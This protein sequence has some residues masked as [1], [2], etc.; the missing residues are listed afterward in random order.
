VDIQLRRLEHRLAEQRLSLHVTPAARAALAEEG[1]D[2]VYGARPLR[3]DD[4]ATRPGSPGEFKP[5]DTVVVDWVDD[6]GFT[7]A[8]AVEAEAVPV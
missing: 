6:A 5:G 8:P 4:S 7:F 1:Y 2:P 3:A